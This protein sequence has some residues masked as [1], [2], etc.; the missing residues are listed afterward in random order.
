MWRRRVYAEEQTGDQTGTGRTSN[1]TRKEPAA[2]ISSSKP[3]EIPVARKIAVSAEKDAGALPEIG[4][5]GDIRLCR[6]GAGFDPC[7]PPAHIVGCPEIRVPVSAPDLQA[8]E[9]VDQE[10]VDHTSD[11][12]GA[13]HSRGAILKNVHV[14]DHRKGYQVNVRAVVSP[15]GGQ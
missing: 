8:A 15:S 9:F 4:N 3:V 11:G 13:V 14:I 5:D 6:P 7:F 1:V 12:V 10:E 2:S